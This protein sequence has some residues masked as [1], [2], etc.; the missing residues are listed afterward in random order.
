MPDLR[1]NNGDPLAM[2]RPSVLLVDDTPANLIALSA[3][4][5]PLGV[6]LVEARNGREA[7][8]RVTNEPFA[9]VLLDAQMPEMD[10]FEVA[11][12]IRKLEHGREVPI[13]F[14]TAIHRDEL[15]A[16]RGYAKGAADYMTKPFDADIL[17]ARVKAFVD[18]FRQREEVRRAQLALRT[19]ERD[20]AVRRLV[21]FERIATAVLERSDLDAFLHELLDIFAGATDEVDSAAILLR[22]RD[23]L[24]LR[25][26]VGR[27][28]QHDHSLASER[29]GE[30]FAGRI[31]ATGQ[32]WE[33]GEAA[34]SPIVASPWFRTGDTRAIFGVPL[35]NDGEVLGVAFVA[36]SETGAFAQRDKRLF[37]AV[38]ERASWAVAKYEERTRL[39][40]VLEASPA[41]IAITRGPD[42]QCEFANP[43]FKDFFNDAGRAG[44]RLATLGVT[45]AAL[46]V[47]DHVYR[48]GEMVSSRELPLVVDWR[49][50]EPPDTRYLDV[51]AQRLRTPIGATDELLVFAVDVTAQVRA[52]QDLEHHQSER[53]RLLES[54]RA[55]RQEAEVAN[56]AK[57]EFLATVSHELRTPLNAIIGWTAIARAQAPA[58]LDRALS[59]IERNARSQARIIEDV[60]DVSRIIS[61]QLRLEPRALHLADPLSAAV[62]SVRPGAETKEI[63]LDVDVA[64]DVTIVGDP[65]RLQ[66]IVWNLLANAIKFTPR[67][68]RVALHAKR[69]GEVACIEVIDSGQGIEPAFLPRV[70]DPFRQADGSTTRRHGGLGLGL[71]IVK[72]LAAAHGGTVRA[73]SEGMGRGATFV[74]ELPIGSRPTMPHGVTGLDREPVV[75]HG[76]PDVRLDG[77]DVLVVDDEEDAR[78]LVAE[79]LVARGAK[80]RSAS[81]AG[82][83][84][85]LF[86]AACP[87]VLVSDIGMPDRDG[88]SLI[89]AIRKLPASRG[90]RTPA[91]A[92]TAYARSEDVERAF[93]AGFQRH[94]E[95]PVDL[96]KLI[97]LVANLGGR[98]FGGA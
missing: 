97:S 46:A 40:D 29:I 73:K 77:L 66:Q 32:P 60:L 24:R 8:E 33:I 27:I 51:T 36:S 31:A 22:Q 11:E 82:E 89:R 23:D 17:R 57:D 9:V 95:K 16:R 70:F 41:L 64:Q 91:V 92:L 87:D 49:A 88:Y 81:S 61:G 50:G 56:R 45:G 30:G 78:A 12:H 3:V 37:L 83:A 39:R 26:A 58:E 86:E 62:E 19:E 93:S 63:T 15:Y 96:S 74:V 67:G 34:S 98:S 75:L 54:E 69:Q 20:E 59:I 72:Q 4:L 6:R 52:R 90:G 84:L 28:A 79:V 7:L 47:L 65:E 2:I 38:A 71:A 53:A 80:V 5:S 44:V 21:A 18:L 1:A 43:A 35:T 48:S 94:V 85:S 76:T 14:L 25:A 55:A 68:G 13:I 10:G 42:H